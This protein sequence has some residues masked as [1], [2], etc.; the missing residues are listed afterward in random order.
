MN[1]NILLADTTIFFSP[2]FS[3]EKRTS[4]IVCGF[5]VKIYRSV[6]AHGTEGGLQI[7]AMMLDERHGKK[8]IH[9]MIL[10]NGVKQRCLAMS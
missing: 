9:F 8:N 7:M 2:E 4:E 3:P 6:Y 1:E 5:Q 10:S